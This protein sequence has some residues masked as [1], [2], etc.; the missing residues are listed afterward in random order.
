MAADTVTLDREAV[1]DL[2]VEV[3]AVTT[4]L[5]RIAGVCPTTLTEALVNK[6]ER[7]AEAVLGELSPNRDTGPRVE[8]WDA[9]DRGAD[10][11]LRPLVRGEGDADAE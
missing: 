2:L 11:F 9:G 8:L 1:M 3:H 5:E 7:V 4:V 6:T 10:D